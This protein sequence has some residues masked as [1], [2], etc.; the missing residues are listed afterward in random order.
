[1][2]RRGEEKFLAQECR[3]E[4]LEARKSI[5]HSRNQKAASVA[6]AESKRSSYVR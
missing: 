3:W 1:M 2:K 4:D 5:A 6:G